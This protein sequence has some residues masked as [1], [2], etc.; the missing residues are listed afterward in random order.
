MV[1]ESRKW[2]WV[3]RSEEAE[4]TEIINVDKDEDE[5]WLHFAV[6]AHLTE[7]H[8]DTLRALMMTLDTLSMDFLAFWQD[9][10]NL[11]MS[12]LRAMEAI[13]DKLQQLNDLKEEE[14][15]MEDLAQGSEVGMHRLGVWSWLAQVLLV[16]VPNEFRGIPQLCG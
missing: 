13:V 7:E 4:E 6:L 3:W 12:I 11:G 16:E 5:E 8:W 15:G 2:K 14:M 9:S 1:R 10:W